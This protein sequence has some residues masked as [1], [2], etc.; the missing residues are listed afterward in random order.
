MAKT[1]MNRG[2][3]GGERVEEGVGRESTPSAS[4]DVSSLLQTKLRMSD[5]NHC[6]TVTMYRVRK[7]CVT[8][9]KT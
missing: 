7:Y 8:K 5:Y 2:V 1:Y 4:T 9:R 6:V 3:E